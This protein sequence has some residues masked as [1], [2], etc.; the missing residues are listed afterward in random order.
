MASTATNT[1]A[2]QE[3]TLLG[4]FLGYV[5]PHSIK[6]WL[7][8]ESK[9]QTIYVSPIKRGLLSFRP[10]RPATTLER[11]AYT[12]SRSGHHTPV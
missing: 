2:P 3:P 1:P 11:R 7:H 6:I 12:Q 8:H 9:P 10:A 4:P 5:T